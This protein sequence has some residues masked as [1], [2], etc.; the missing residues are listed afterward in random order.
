MTLSDGNIDLAQIPSGTIGEGLTV[1]VWVGEVGDKLGS[2]T[3]TFELSVLPGTAPDPDADSATVK[4]DLAKGASRAHYGA[5]VTF[6]VQLQ[7]TDDKGTVAGADDE[8]VNVGLKGDAKVEY[9]LVI[10]T[11]AGE[12]DVDGDIVGGANDGQDATA[13]TRSTQTLKVGADGSATFTLNHSDPDAENRGN[14][15][16][17]RYMLIGGQAETA[18]AI[19]VIVF[20]DAAPVV[21][22]LSID[23]GAYQPAPGPAP[24]SAGNAVTVTVVDQYGD[25]FRGARVTLTSG[26]AGSSLNTD[27]VEANGGDADT[28][29][30]GLSRITGR[31]GSVRIGY[32]RSGTAAVE[33]LRATWDGFRPAVAGV[34]ANGDGDF[35]DDGDT[36]AVAEVGTKGIAAPGAECQTP[37]DVC[38]DGMV[39]WV[40]ATED[41]GDDT[42]Y[43]VLNA[44][45]EG[46]EVIVDTDDD[47]QTV[48]PTSVNFDSNDF[49]TVDGTPSSM[50]DFVT[51]LGKAMARDAEL[52]AAGEDAGTLTL[53]WSSYIFDDPSD[54]ASFTLVTITA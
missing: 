16:T 43:N 1:W 2:G 48:I 10:Q 44:D 11:F 30:D 19:G 21:S 18:P 20:A 26:L 36:A 45:L 42:A 51:A 35:T 17:A 40:D 12:V 8:K 39:F 53:A 24:A 52:V 27:S 22:G 9:T 31:N 13:N 38:A 14:T 47:A 4:S 6:T 28:D 15:N 37:E 54:I 29:P 5:A 7:G 46:G 41:A 3:D 33:S 32:G 25:P 49:F 34:D 23:A 50:A